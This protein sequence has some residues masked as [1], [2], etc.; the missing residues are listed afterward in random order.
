VGIRSRA[1]IQSG[2]HC[3]ATCGAERHRLSNS[4]PPFRRRL[5]YAVLSAVL[6]A[7]LFAAS[8]AAQARMINA[9]SP[10]LADVRRAVASAVDGDTV[11]VPADSGTDYS[12]FGYG[13]VQRSND[14]TG[15]FSCR[16]SRGR[17]LFP[18]HSEHWTVSSDN[19]HNLH[20]CSRKHSYTS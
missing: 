19:R 2:M 7:L 20:E 15:Q 8:S 6:A 14:S 3:D 17:R 13:G 4:D 10:S 16:L 9:A 18:L 11:I 12:Q 1:R 5:N